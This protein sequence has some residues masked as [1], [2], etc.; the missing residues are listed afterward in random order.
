MVLQGKGHNQD[1]L[2]GKELHNFLGPGRARLSGTLRK[3]RMN[4]CLSSCPASFLLGMIATRTNAQ[5]PRPSIQPCVLPAPLAG[6]CSLQLSAHPVCL[7]PFVFHWSKEDSS[8]TDSSE[9]LCLWL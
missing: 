9:S 4:H 7:D 3:T 6:E 2:A 8:E 5:A 1:L